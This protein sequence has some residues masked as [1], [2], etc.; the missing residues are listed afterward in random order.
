MSI[1]LSFLGSLRDFWALIIVSKNTAQNVF[2]FMHKQ[3]SKNRNSLPTHGW[4]SFDGTSLN[5]LPW[6]YH[7]LPWG[8]HPLVGPV[9][10]PRCPNARNFLFKQ[11]MLQKESTPVFDEAFSDGVNQLANNN[12]RLTIYGVRLLLRAH[13]VWNWVRS[14][15]Q[16]L[17]TG[18]IILHV[19]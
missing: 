17:V 15:R 13:W 5:P 10:H 16:N 11:L 14:I 2:T 6:G 3:V 8:Y 19:S 7:P 9:G 18:K 4:I 12:R 1:V